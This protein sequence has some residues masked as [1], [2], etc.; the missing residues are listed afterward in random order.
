[1]FSSAEIG[2]LR[3]KLD[4]TEQMLAQSLRRQDFVDIELHKLESQMKM[5]LRIVQP[6]SATLVRKL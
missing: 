4:E 5:F 6:A 3:L 2:R 1:M